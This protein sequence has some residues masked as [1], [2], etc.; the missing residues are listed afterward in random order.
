MTAIQSPGVFANYEGN[1]TKKLQMLR[2]TTIFNLETPNF[3]SRIALCSF[4]TKIK[5]LWG[6]VGKILERDKL[7][8]RAETGKCSIFQ[9]F[10]GK[11]PQFVPEW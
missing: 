8:N 7:K 6:W 9:G 2:E 11:F 5:L 4:I 3:V 1:V 10:E